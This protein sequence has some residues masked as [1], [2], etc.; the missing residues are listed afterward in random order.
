MCL[1][2]VQ[3]VSKCMP[4]VYNCSAAYI[5]LVYISL[6]QY[7]YKCSAVFV[8]VQCSMFISVVQHVYECSSL[9]V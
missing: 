1:S 4:Y 7:V 9:C 8:S 2:V 3:Y 5:S 6:V